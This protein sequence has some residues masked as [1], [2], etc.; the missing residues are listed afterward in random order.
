MGSSPTTDSNVNSGRYTAPQPMPQPS[1]QPTPTPQPTPQPQPTP[2]SDCPGGSLAACIGLCP[3]GA[4]FQVCVDSCQERCSVPQCGNNDGDD[5]GTCV[6]GCPTDKFVECIDCCEGK[7]P[8]Q[9][10]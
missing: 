6:R 1:P 10:I 9:M 2:S 3:S 8:S 5:L 7:F 4:V